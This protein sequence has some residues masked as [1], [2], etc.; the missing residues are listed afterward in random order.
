MI[1]PAGITVHILPG[2]EIRFDKKCSI[3][4]Y[5][6]IIA[7]GTSDDKIRFFGY[8]NNGKSWGSILLRGE[9]TEG[10]FEYC[11][12]DN[13][14]GEYLVGVDYTG[15]LTAHNAKLMIVRSSLFTNAKGD[16]GLNCKYTKCIVEDNIFRDNAM[17]AIDFDFAQPESYI[18]RNEF[19]DNGNDAIDL[20]GTSIEIFN[21]NIYRSGD[22]CI[23][24]GEDSHPIIYD[25][26]FQECLIGIEAKDN[27]I[28]NIGYNIFIRNGTALS[29]YM[30]KYRF[31]RG[32]I[33]KITESD[34][35]ENEVLQITDEYSTIEIS[36]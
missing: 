19:Y 18:T 5:G 6:N 22:K 12:F 36:E 17:D 30:K 10:V 20:S 25:N 7:K 34:F 3:I 16:D 13:G 9:N 31:A 15:M 33:I 29:A 21:N 1:I 8:N 35:I 14:G 23:S 27:S 26:L 11:E 4:V 28:P 24:I 32:G 2:T